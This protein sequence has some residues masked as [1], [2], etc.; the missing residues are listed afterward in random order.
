MKTFQQAII[1]S[2]LVAAAVAQKQSTTKDG[3]AQS[4]N[5][6]NGL[7]ETSLIAVIAGFGVFGIMY[8]FTIVMIFTDMSKREKGYDNDIEVDK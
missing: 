4:A 3:F 5:Q 2:A 6:S 8:V 7:T 1:A